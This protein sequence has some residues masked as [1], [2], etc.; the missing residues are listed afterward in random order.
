MHRFQ[1]V[2]VLSLLA[3]SLP[4][5]FDGDGERQ[6]GAAEAWHLDLNRRCQL[7][8]QERHGLGPERHGYIVGICAR[9]RR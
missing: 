5:C 6:E 2:I 8:S 4:A 7:A 1:I 9:G 3:F